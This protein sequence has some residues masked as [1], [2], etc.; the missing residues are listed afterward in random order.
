MT[1]AEAIPI[2]RYDGN[3]SATNFPFTQIFYEDDDL[4]VILTDT[5]GNDITLTETDYDVN[6]VGTTSGSIDFPASGSSYGT[7][8]TG[9]QLTILR[10]TDKDRDTDLSG[11]YKFST[12]NTDADRAVAMAQE[13]AEAISRCSKYKP[14][15][16]ATPPDLEDLE[17]TPVSDVERTIQFRIFPADASVATGDGVVFAGI[18]AEYNGW[19]IV[20][21]TAYVDTLGTP[22]GSET[23]DIQLRRKRLAAS[24][25]VL[26][27]K[28]TL[29][30]TEYYAAD[31]SV[32]TANN[33]LATG[34]RLFIDIDNTQLTT[35]PLGL[36]VDVRIQAP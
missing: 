23:T 36:C 9:Y 33:T 28:V 11:V 2:F 19:K 15:N 18:G 29:D 1:I 27:T 12:V 5:G 13:N 16:S 14:S 31:G 17:L 20:D 22:T 6:G 7:L 26:T 4:L 8:A 3:D 21:V 10:V 30:D 25:D 35:A 32:N 34:D 24:V